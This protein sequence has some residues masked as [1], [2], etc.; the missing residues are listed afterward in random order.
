MSPSNVV[1]ESLS[2]QWNRL[3]RWKQLLCRQVEDESWQHR[4]QSCQQ[5]WGQLQQ[6]LVIKRGRKLHPPSQRNWTKLWWNQYNGE[7]LEE[8]A[9]SESSQQLQ[10]PVPTYKQWWA[11]VQRKGILPWLCKPIF[12]QSIINGFWSG[13][14][15]DQRCWHHPCCW[16]FCRAIN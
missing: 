7:Q 2:S 12:R 10:Q 8:D 1:K 9:C 14:L 11:G 15:E 5:Q 13:N 4:M 3:L 6:F 16:L